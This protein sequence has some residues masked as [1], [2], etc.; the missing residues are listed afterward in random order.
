MRMAVVGW[1]LRLAPALLATTVLAG[2]DDTPAPPPQDFPALH[3]DYLTPIRLNVADVEVDD[4]STAPDGDLAGR[5]PL[6]PASAMQQMA[7]DRLIA[8]GGAGTA[9]FVVTEASITRT[10]H[11]ITE[12]LAARL[13]IANASGGH[14][15]FAEA[16]V[17]RTETPGNGEPAGPASLY[18]L[19]R[20]AMED[21]NVEFEYQVRHTLHD[22]LIVNGAVEAPVEQAP[23]VP[24][25]PGLGAPGSGP[26]GSGEP[27]PLA[28]GGAPVA[29]VPPPASGFAPGTPMTLT[30]SAPPAASATS[31]GEMSPPA[32][33][34]TAPPGAAPVSGAPSAYAPAYPP[35]AYP[36][37]PYASP[38]YPPSAY[39]P[40]A[41][42]AAPYGNVPPS[43]Q[44][45]PATA[46]QN[47]TGY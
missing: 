6:K 24:G 34:L 41:Y 45:Y 39:P 2:C 19:T 7:H 32:G 33:Y 31:P 25:A 18:E 30:P 8:A 38:S 1:G 15:G 27:L 36:P 35:S 5:S 47:P 13:E 20:Q 28:P 4:Q 44:A 29:V 3:Y 10:D 14:A 40:N 17:T 46:P 23:L 22:W 11:G 21:M 42:P 16:H 12:H 9:T 26:P 43:S 37:S